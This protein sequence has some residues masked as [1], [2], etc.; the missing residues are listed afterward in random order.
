[1]TLRVMFDSNA[2]DAI[3]RHGDAERIDAEMFSIITTT[4]Q[5]DEL[6]QIADPARRAAL[7]EIFHRLHAATADI[8]ADW[9]ASRDN[10]I[11]RAAAEHCDL[12]VTDDRELK[13]WLAIQAPA[14]RVLS[15]AGFRQEFLD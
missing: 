8:P 6:R 5:E 11:G 15:Y 13:D 10:V 9:A 14:L 1:M 3:L 7:L 12:L 4:A 2:Y